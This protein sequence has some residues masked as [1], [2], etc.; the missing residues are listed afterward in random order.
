MQIWIWVLHA[1]KGQRLPLDTGIWM[2]CRRD[3]VGLQA[4]FRIRDILVQ[5]RILR[6]VPLNNGSKCGSGYGFGYGSSSFRQWPLRCLW[7]MDPDPAIFIS[8]LQDAKKKKKF[9]KFLCLF[10]FEGT[11]TVYNSSKIKKI[12]KKSQ[13]SRNQDFFY[14]FAHT[15]KFRIQMRI[16][17]AKKTCRSYE[18]GCGSRT[19]VKSYLLIFHFVP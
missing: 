14:C 8:D 17:E 9:T 4:V 15:N 11:F 1:Q 6:S 13:N 10:L 18:S 7:L 19:L 3:T 16:Q 12:I 5:M 2:L